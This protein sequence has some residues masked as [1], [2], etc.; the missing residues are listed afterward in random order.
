MVVIGV[1]LNQTATVCNKV[2]SYQMTCECEQHQPHSR[3]PFSHQNLQLVAEK[4]GRCPTFTCVTE[5]LACFEFG[6]NL[7]KIKHNLWS[8]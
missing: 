1:S 2:A 4:G 5:P 6:D 3:Q 7:V 8:C